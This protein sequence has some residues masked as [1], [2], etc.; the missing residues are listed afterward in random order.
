MSRVLLVRGEA[1]G[2]VTEATEEGD[3]G[4]GGA[5]DWSGGTPGQ[6]R[7]EEQ[8][9]RQQRELGPVQPHVHLQLVLPQPESQA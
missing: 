4:L 9:V 2:E 3:P 7:G 6:H 1:R 5:G 8:R